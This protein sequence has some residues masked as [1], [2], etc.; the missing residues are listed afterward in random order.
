MFYLE[1]GSETFFYIY[2]YKGTYFFLH[3]GFDTYQFIYFVTPVLNYSYPIHAM[4]TNKQFTQN[5]DKS[6]IPIYLHPRG[7]PYELQPNCLFDN[8]F[9]T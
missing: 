9:Y 2:E 4:L 6:Q 8:I 5:Y 7:K 3:G 1:F